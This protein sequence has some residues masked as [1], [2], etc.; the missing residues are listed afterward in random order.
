MRLVGLCCLVGGSLALSGCG[1]SSKKVAAPPASQLGTATSTATG[2]ASAGS[3][4]KAGSIDVCGLLSQDDAAAVARQHALNGAQTAATVYTVKATK[5]SYPQSSPVPT[6]GCSFSIDGQG[7]SGTV[8]IEVTSADNFA[9]IYGSG[10]K[11]PGLGDEAYRDSGSTVVR[12]GDLML[13]TSEDSF[14]D[15]FVVDLYRKM[16]PHLK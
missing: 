1:G 2:T 7:A 16:I 11:V 10:E 12:V 9:A 15:S 13:Q 3:S 8:V 4:S 5:Q 6:S 14:T